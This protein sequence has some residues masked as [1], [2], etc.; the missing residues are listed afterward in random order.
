MTY[1]DVVME[2]AELRKTKLRSLAHT[3]GRN[4]PSDEDLVWYKERMKAYNKE[5]RRLQKLLKELK[6]W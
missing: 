3:F 2:L 4:G 5:Y 1:S 6:S